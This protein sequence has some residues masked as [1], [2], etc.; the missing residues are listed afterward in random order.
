MILGN[1]VDIVEV[2]RFKRWTDFTDE[3]LTRV[4]NP[5]E[6]AA[7]KR[8]DG[9]YVFEKLATRFAAKEAFY[10]ALSAALV[11]LDMTQ[12][13]FSFLSIASLI[14][15]SQDVWNVPQITFDTKLF[16][17][18]TKITLPKVRIHVSLAHEK[19]HAIAFVTISQ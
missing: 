4:Y 2:C 7:C 5:T 13:T 19:S 17:E 15:V 3:K 8:P 12:R 16:E 11:T 9:T 14:C 1:G 18:K 10:K 6:L